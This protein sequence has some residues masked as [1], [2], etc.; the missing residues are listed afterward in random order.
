MKILNH[1]KKIYSEAISVLGFIQCN[2]RHAKHGQK[3]TTCKVYLG[4]IFYSFGLVLPK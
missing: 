3:D 1:I 4:I 2:L